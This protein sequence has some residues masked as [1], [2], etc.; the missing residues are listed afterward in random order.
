M[1][2]I[3]STMGKFAV[4]S[5]SKT[6]WTKAS[7]ELKALKIRWIDPESPLGQVAKESPYL[8]DSECARVAQKA[9]LARWKHGLVDL[10]IEEL[11][12]WASGLSDVA[13]DQGAQDRQRQDEVPQVR[14]G[15]VRPG[16]RRDEVPHAR[17]GQV[18]P[19]Q[20]QEEVPRAQQ[21]E[22]AD[23][24]YGWPKN[25]P[26][27]P[28]PLDSRQDWLTPARYALDEQ[29]RASF[30]HPEQQHDVQ[31][32]PSGLVEAEQR[33][34][35]VPH[36]LPGLDDSGQCRDEVPQVRPGK[37]GPGQRQDE[38]PHA[39]LGQVGPGQRQDEV[40]QA[41]PG[42]VGPGQRQD[43]VPQAQPGLV[44]QGQHQD[45]VPHA[46][47]GQVEAPRLSPTSRAIM[48]G[49]SLWRLPEI[50]K[51]LAKGAQQPDT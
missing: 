33:H 25:L 32:A 19:G 22:E 11:G 3:E 14:P 8:L 48:L 37:V 43:E 41:Q 35:E 5:L 49:P 9:Y 10:S 39:H 36:D 12:E 21:V 15:Q 17:P 40:P 26:P 4:S 27:M 38:V 23:E 31:V 6:Y 24:D 16:Q 29:M 7:L 13:P 18:D 34:D 45:E 46:H 51:Y 42:Q 1:L 20:G 30:H 2:F 50:N 28:P 47:P 44:G